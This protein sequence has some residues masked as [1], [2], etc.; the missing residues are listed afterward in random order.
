MPTM[1][2]MELIQERSADGTIVLRA[3]V[4]GPAERLRRLVRRL[5]RRA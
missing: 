5:T 4:L 2:R 3:V 1:T